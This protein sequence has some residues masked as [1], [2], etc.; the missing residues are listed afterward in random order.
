MSQPITKVQG[1]S[2]SVW[3]E[4]ARDGGRDLILLVAVSGCDVQDAPDRVCVYL[5]STQA[6][7][8]AKSLIAACRGQM[9]TA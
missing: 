7:A 1:E 8:L 6:L 9:N 5:T 4:A 3:A 2:G